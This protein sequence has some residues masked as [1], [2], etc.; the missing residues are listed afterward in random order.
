MTAAEGG[1]G[2]DHV[3]TMARSRDLFGPYELHPQTFLLTSKDAPDAPLQRAGH[4]QIV[5][6]PEGLTYHTHLCSRPLPG[7]RRSPL[8]RETAIQ[9]CVWRDDGWLY[10]EHGGLVPA[11][12]VPAPPGA[13]EPEPDRPVE[14]RFDGPALPED[15]QWLRTP[16]PERLFT[17]TGDD[18]APSRPRVDRLVVRAGAGRPPPA[19]SPLPRRDPPRRLMPPANAT[20]SPLCSHCT[21]SRSV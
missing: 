19:A 21:A 6:T 11:L 1:T 8:G 16:Y 13:P 9:K 4:G 14:Y 2:Y 10:L 3:V 7:L 20:T 18:L 15:F 5:E 17:L 12:E